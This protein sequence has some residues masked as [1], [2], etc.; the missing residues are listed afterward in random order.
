MPPSGSNRASKPQKI[1][2]ALQISHLLQ[3]HPPMPQEQIHNFIQASSDALL[4][5]VL[6]TT[7]S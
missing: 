4:A 3:P 7:E 5:S 1:Q 6:F 2:Y